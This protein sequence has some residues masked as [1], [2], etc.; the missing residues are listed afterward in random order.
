[1]TDPVWGLSPRDRV[2]QLPPRADILIVGGGITGVSLLYHLGHAGAVLVERDRLAAGASGRNA[3]FIVQG[4]GS[5]YAEAVRTH[6]RARARATWAFSVETHNLLAEA[7]AGRSPH[8]RRRSH[9]SLPVDDAERHQLEESATLMAE[10]GLAAR[11]DGERLFLPG[12]GEHNPME[13]VCALASFAPAGAIREGV[14]ATS[15]EACSDDVR[16]HAQN[17]ECR[18]GTV[19]LATNAYT[20]RLLP[21]ADITPNRA[22]MV[23]TA[24]EQRSIAGCPTARNHGFQYWNQLWDGRVA[25][26]GYRDQAVEEERTAEATTN[27]KLQAC[28]DAHLREWG[29]RAPVTHR[30]AGIMGFTLDG[31]PVV[32]QVRPNVWVCGGYNGSGMSFAFHCARRVAE[33]LTGRRS[34]PIV[35]WA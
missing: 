31:L 2:G 9:V 30:W 18:A 6:G 14:E 20:S 5:N 32:R 28:L 13:S 8:Y 1:M 27:P 7:L 17:S 35:P 12:D 11:W 23:A 34:A 26:G 19:V 15:I 24:P 29:V 16:V 22:Q 4:V 10:D 3:G 25:A 33:H 21:E